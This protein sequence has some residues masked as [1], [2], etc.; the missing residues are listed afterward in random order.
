MQHLYNDLIV[1]LRNNEKILPTKL[2]RVMTKT[3]FMISSMIIIVPM[4]EQHS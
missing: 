3:L 1:S 2:L 4:H